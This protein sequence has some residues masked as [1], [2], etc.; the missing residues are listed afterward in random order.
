LIEQTL[1]PATADTLA[2]FE[3]AD[4]DVLVFPYETNFAGVIS[5]PV[6]KLE[7]PS[8]VSSAVPAPATLAG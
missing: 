1:P 7:D 4:V 5:N 3:R 2:L 6:Y 8:Y